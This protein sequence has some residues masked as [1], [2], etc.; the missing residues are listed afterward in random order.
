MQSS[1]VFALRSLPQRWL[2]FHEK[3]K[4]T[5]VYVRETTAVRPEALLLFGGAIEIQ[6]RTLTDPFQP[7]PHGAHPHLSASSHSTSGRRSRSTDGS[8]SKRPRR[9]PF[10]SRSC[11]AGWTRC[12]S[13]RSSLRPSTSRRATT[14]SFRPSAH[15]CAP[16]ARITL[17]PAAEPP[18]PLSARRYR[19]AARR[20]REF[21]AACR[22][23]PPR[24]W[25]GPVALGRTVCVASDLI[26]LCRCSCARA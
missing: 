11:A 20:G 16:R 17:R 13:R 15:C 22:R 1:V 2:V 25:L 6:V 8:R 5:K 12:S 9:S 10:S 3:M 21:H 23:W 18:V 24:R 19:C 4:T 26:G 14:G 7:T